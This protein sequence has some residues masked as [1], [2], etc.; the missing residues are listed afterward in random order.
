MVCLRR[1]SEPSHDVLVVQVTF[2]QGDLLEMQMGQGRRV[3][4][5]KRR[6]FQTETDETDLALGFQTPLGLEV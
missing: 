1:I 5:E 2:V 3:D 4:M 6:T